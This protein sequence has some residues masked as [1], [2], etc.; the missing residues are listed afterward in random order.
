[1]CSSHCSSDEQTSNPVNQTAR[2]K[3]PDTHTCQSNITGYNTRHTYLSIK[4]HGVQHQ[5]HIP[6]NQTSRGITPDTHTCQSNITGNNTR[7]TY[8][9]VKKRV[10]QN[11]R[12]ILVSERTLQKKID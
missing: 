11:K 7:H 9:S 8:L 12:E 3:T 5:T 2:G 1:M 6:V 10:V 4:Q